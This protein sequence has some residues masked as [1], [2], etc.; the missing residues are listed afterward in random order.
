M[1]RV[2]IP[3]L[4]VESLRTFKKNRFTNFPPNSLIMLKVFITGAS[5]FIASNI[6]KQFV[7]NGYHVI[8]TVR[9][10]AKGDKLKQLFGDKFD[11]EVVENMIK[12]GAFDN[13]L[14]NHKDVK[15]LLH[16]ASPFFYDTT[17]P[18]NDLVIPAI[19]GTENILK[20]IKAHG[21]QIERVVITSSDAAI[22]S[23]VDEQDASL[24]FDET[25]WNNITYEEAIK[26]PVAAYYGAKSFAEKLAWE[27]VK[28]ENPNFELVAVNPVYVFGPQVDSNDAK[29]TLN[30]SNELIADVLKLKDNDFA[31][32][33]G[34][35]V[36]VRDVAKVHLLAIERPETTGKRLYCTGG[37]FSTQ[38]I[39]DIV[40]DKFPQLNLPK[41]HP[42]AGPSHI[43]TLAKTSNEKTKTLL[44]FEFTGLEKIIVDTVEQVLKAR[45]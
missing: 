24:S 38:M 18:E 37:K 20:S 19:K 11:Y 39:L 33:K 2:I 1:P 4:V 13:A 41:G 29:G 44:N 23:S 36:D 34:G 45:S 22:Y 14:K 43:A 26:D 17:D 6:V 32:D 31:I 10:S 8:G 7:D 28:N 3:D 30:V 25:S 40:N 12:E 21:P 5:G 15:Y 35:F 16:T 9:S 42:G 27:F